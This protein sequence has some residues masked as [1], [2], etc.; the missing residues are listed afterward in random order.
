V[1]NTPYP[2]FEVYPSADN[3]WRWR[4][5][6]ANH[7]IVAASVDGFSSPNHAMR[8]V[9]DTSDNV[10]TALGIV[11]GIKRSARVVVQADEN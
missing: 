9:V 2:R 7:E 1:N 3:E 4:L 11:D 6:A 10:L 5:K 8:A